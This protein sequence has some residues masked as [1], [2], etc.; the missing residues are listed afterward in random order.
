VLALAKLLQ[1]EYKDVPPRHF[2]FS[3]SLMPSCYYHIYRASDGREGNLIANE[4]GVH[5]TYSDAESETLDVDDWEE[6]LRDR[7]F[8]IMPAV[9][10]SGA[11]VRLQDLVNVGCPVPDGTR[12]SVQEQGGLEMDEY[13]NYNHVQFC[14]HLLVDENAIMAVPVLY[15]IENLVVPGQEIWIKSGSQAWED[16]RDFFPDTDLPEEEAEKRMICARLNV[17]LILNPVPGIVYLT[18]LEKPRGSSYMGDVTHRHVTASPW[19]L[20]LASPMNPKMK[21]TELWV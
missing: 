18:V 11:L 4:F 10:R 12:S 2:R 19:E 15:L 16:L 3:Y 7:D 21:I 14:Y 9:F 8:L 13:M 6:G 1:C 17:P 20:S 5:V